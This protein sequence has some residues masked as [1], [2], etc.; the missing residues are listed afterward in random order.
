MIFVSLFLFLLGV[1]CL[2]QVYRIK[3]WRSQVLLLFQPPRI[4]VGG[5]KIS[6]IGI[7]LLSGIGIYYL[8]KHHLPLA[9]WFLGF[10]S[11]AGISL[12][13][14]ILGVGQ[15]ILGKLGDDDNPS[16]TS[17]DQALLK[18]SAGFAF[19]AA[20]LSH[21]LYVSLFDPDYPQG[22]VQNPPPV[23]IG[24]S[25]FIAGTAWS[26][27]SMMVGILLYTRKAGEEMDVRNI[28]G[29]NDLASRN[30][31]FVSSRAPFSRGL[32]QSF[33]SIFTY[34]MLSLAFLLPPFV[35]KSELALLWGRIGLL[36][37]PILLF[38]ATL[39]ILLPFRK[40][41]LTESL[42]EKTVSVSIPFLFLLFAFLLIWKT[43]EKG[44]VKS[45]AYSLTS[46]LPGYI[47]GTFFRR[48]GVRI[49]RSPGDNRF[50]VLGFLALFLPFGILLSQ[51]SG[52]IG[53]M[54]FFFSLLSGESWGRVCPQRWPAPRED[55]GPILSLI[56]FLIFL[57]SYLLTL[58]D[59]TSEGNPFSETFPWVLLAG[60]LAFLIYFL[61][62]K[63]AVGGF[64]S[65]RASNGDPAS[66]P[67][68]ERW[69]N[70]D[71][72]LIVALHLTFLPLGLLFSGVLDP[73]RGMI[74]LKSLG[75]GWLVVLYFVALMSRATLGE[76]DDG[77]SRIG[78]R[79]QVGAYPYLALWFYG[80]LFLGWISALTFEAL[81]TPST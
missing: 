71:I 13:T 20:S 46:S 33:E 9:V 75:G 50:I 7:I 61:L 8:R 21:L 6:I 52:E 51:L 30:I 54:F 19:I 53:G 39:P 4:L 73:G 67:S 58:K 32:V 1:I 68:S 72:R 38:L 36:L 16:V 25:L 17:G 66:S 77:K 64:F 27:L 47:L 34:L 37:G 2:T 35:L 80:I 69:I 55:P 62:D 11:G 48:T 44:I 3:G 60:I 43:Q 24:F 28:R 14:W 18:K 29:R 41:N 23:L 70:F 31:T 56:V 81:L 79:D 63:G 10:L 59:A 49:L 78:N 65:T 76:M 57:F 74:L 12:L 5:I 26:F 42:Q 40:N 22:S 15:S 45:L